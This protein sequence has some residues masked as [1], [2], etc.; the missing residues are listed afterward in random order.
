M[1]DNK[2]E[3]IL[4]KD[5]EWSVIDGE[6]CKV[7]EFI[8]AATVQN[9]KVLAPNKTEPYAS[10]ILECK[11][12]PTTIKGFICHKMDFQHLWAAFKERRVR[13]NEEV[14]IFYSKKQLKNYAKIFSAFMPRLWI[15]ICQKGAFELMTD[16]NSRPELQGE[17]RFLAERPIVEWKPEVMK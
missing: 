14:I 15:L 8:P 2:T 6:P 10:V 13:Q 9:G 4:L 1:Q 17:A 12:M 11:K 7:L 16:P 5:S 3:I